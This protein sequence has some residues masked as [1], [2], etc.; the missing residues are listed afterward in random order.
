MVINKTYYI[1]NLGKKEL[2]KMKQK[3]DS[4]S[5]AME[6]FAEGVVKDLTEFGVEKMEEI[7]ST[8][9]LKG[10]EPLQFYISGTPLDKKVNMA[11][12]QAIYN[13]FG[14]GTE[15][16]LNPHPIKSSFSLNDYNSGPTIR[17]AKPN[18]RAVEEGIPEGDLYWTYI[19]SSGKKQYTQGTPAQREVYDS[20]VAT[21]SKSDEIVKK[22]FLERVLK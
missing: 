21:I 16:Q 14:T 10:N 20:F 13:E 15:G 8:Y 11:G 19:D 17:K 2:E 3:I 4:W 6:D 12:K 18:S 7:Y 9:P 22:N 1:D 5:I